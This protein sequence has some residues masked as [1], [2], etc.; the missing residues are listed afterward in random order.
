[1]RARARPEEVGRCAAVLAPPRV[2]L[3]YLL[4][5]FFGEL[6]LHRLAA[7]ARRRARR[8]AECQT[9]RRPERVLKNQHM[10][11]AKFLALA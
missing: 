8:P 3:V 6:D 11:V 2:D 1:V 5:G 4:I 7:L 9:H 10:V